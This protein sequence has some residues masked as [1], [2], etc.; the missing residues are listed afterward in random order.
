[1]TDVRKDAHH[2][3]H[4]RVTYGSSGHCWLTLDKAESGG[5]TL[6]QDVLA[7]LDEIVSALE[8]RSDLPGAV[9]RS[10]KRSGFILGADVREF[11]GLQDPAAAGKIAAA[12]QALFQRIEDL[13]FPT[14]AVLN[15]FTLGGG[16][17]LALACRYRVAVEGY[18]RCIG[19][20]EVQ[21]GIHP[22]F[23]GTVR[24]IRLL[25][26]L[27]GLD[28]ILTGRSLSPVEALRAGLVDRIAAPGDEATA[29][30]KL[31]RRSPPVHR[32]PWYLDFL[33]TSRLRPLIAKRLRREVARKARPEH[34]PAPY[35]IVDLWEHYGAKGAAAYRA[36]A[37]S[38]GRLLV[39]PTSKNLVRLFLLRE[40]L[41]NLAPKSDAVSRVHVV[42]AGVMGGDIAAWCALKGLE[43]TMQDREE[44]YLTPAFDRA[45]I[46]F[47][48]RLKAPGAAAA[49]AKRLVGD[50]PGEGV[51]TSDVII[52][53]II[54]DLEAKRSL[55]K[56]LEGRAG[57]QTILA[58]NTSS[59]P[60]ETIGTVLKKPNRLVGLH[61]FNPV[62]SM[63]LVEVIHTGKTD[64]DVINR[65][66][67]FVTQIGK[68]PLPCS[69]AP[70][71]V[72]NRILLPYMLEALT[73]HEDGHAIET[74]DAAARRFGMPMG[75]IELADRVGL[76]TALHVA[77]IMAEPLGTEPP[78]VLHEMVEAG[79]IGVKS[80]QGGF[81]RYEKGRPVRR[82]S[83]PAPDA[84]LI[85][86][87]I[88]RLV[89]EAAACFSDGVVDDLDLLDAGVVFGTGFAPYTGGPIQYAR[90]CGTDGIIGRLEKLASRFGPRFQPHSAW[91]EILASQ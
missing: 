57:A 49:A 15:G 59:I 72:V 68:L 46:L 52:E 42:G 65:A 84:E 25:G 14:V 63:P 34:Y 29:A 53:A 2:V 30:L 12:G 18:E 67:A 55:F 3:K 85:D 6:S 54:E 61:F 4:W 50:V 27:Q 76:D 86:R 58:T 90:S 60:I 36:E 39:S 19:L 75:P 44:K 47:A 26:P 22:G 48:K 1:L 35:A 80:E 74:V 87:L 20:P 43:V 62:A 8:Q 28:L 13:P 7:E 69:S 32:A 5:N 24:A 10:G 31:L 11:E 71:F 38:I 77:G 9:I 21:L 83:F 91:P 88:L 89:N 64:P 70:G 73:A 45:R 66:L 81:Y 79:R 51:P 82:S 33:N 17:E 37:D 40:R 56:E 23:G 78:E 16:L 41:R